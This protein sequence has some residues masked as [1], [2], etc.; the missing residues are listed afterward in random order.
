M[1][2]M[3]TF[4]ACILFSISCAF[5]QTDKSTTL[6]GQTSRLKTFLD[7]HEIE[8]AYLHF[9]KPYY[10]AGDTIYFKA[11]VIAGEKNA[12]S[13]LSG[14]LYT[15]L[16]D[17]QNKILK[18]IKLQVIDGLAWGDI[19]L[20]DSLP[21][22]NYRVRA[23]TKLM[24]NYG[25]ELFFDRVI[26]IGAIIKPAATKA[27]AALPKNKNTAAALPDI[28]FFPEGGD[29]VTGVPSKIA[30]K[31]I[32]PRGGGV[33]VSGTVLNNSN[34]PVAK[35][36]S[37]HLGMGVFSITPIAGETYHAELVYADGSK[38]SVALPPARPDG[39]A[40]AVYDSTLKISVH[41]NP[42]TAFYEQNKNQPLGLFIYSGGRL[43]TVSDVMDGPD[44][45]FDIQK[46][47]LHSGI[48]QITLLSSKGEP[49]CERLVFINK[50]DKLDVSIATNKKEYKQREQ[51][52][53]SL[54]VE[55]TDF[56]AAPAHFS[57][58]VIDRGKVLVDEDKEENILTYLLLTSCL[59]GNIEEP[60]YY[61][62]NTDDKKRSELDLVMLTHGYRRFTWKALANNDMPPPTDPAEKSLNITGLAK[63]VWGKPLNNGLITLIPQAGGGLLSE[64]TDSKGV[65][66]FSNLVFYDSTRFVLNAVNA[67]G[68]NNTELTYIPEFRP[69]VDIKFYAST[70]TSSSGIIQAYLQNSKN[71]HEQFLKYYG[72]GI[73][74][75]EVKIQ[76]VKKPA[77]RTQSL[78]GAGNADVM[79]KGNTLPQ[80]GMLATALAGRIG[81][82]YFSK[83]DEPAGGA[84][85]MQIGSG[86]MLV[87]VDGVQREGKYAV[88]NDIYPSDVETIE[89]LKYASASIYGM[90]GGNG[91]LIITTKQGAG[92]TEKDIISRGVLPLT[93]T[94][95]YKARE[96]YAP[97]YDH[98]ND[99]TRPDLRSTIYW[100]PE[101]SPDKNG[102]ASFDFYNADGTGQY[103]I[104]I[105][106]INNSGIAG[107]AKF[108]Y[109]VKE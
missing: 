24:Q 81:G 74:L 12:L 62:N 47:G 20:P 85:K 63:S 71:Q 54:H 33:N 27:A 95:F 101:I 64:K 34:Q 56:D 25:N 75:K 58:A 52:K 69:P 13:P 73:Q 57:V 49:L 102:N 45:R 109:Q 78:A 44:M 38:A 100:L 107:A 92:T 6:K 94:G 86:P 60:G 46:S 43:T 79:I 67:K 96:F 48:T 66:N 105:E 108:T 80:G 98:I 87:I 2:N 31:A 61:F 7:Q 76:A 3:L 19:A 26:P 15:D 8:K 4:V 59:K 37:V 41:I 97:K 50:D 91:V 77:Y 10:A 5:S 82:V 83:S 23:Y 17:P 18:A 29:M 30:F 14:V 103:Q 35:I 28:Q 84:P 11:Y 89:V 55:D 9:D 72:K 70:D 22:G 16:I 68:K 65:F 40:V 104:I 90:S 21:G 93:I 53:V 36:S 32:V 88:I 1:K 42:S 106:G 39:V 51:V 99:H